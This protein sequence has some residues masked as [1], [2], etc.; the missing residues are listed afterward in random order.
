MFDLK[1][2]IPAPDACL[3]W[4]APTDTGDGGTTLT[5]LN[6]NVKLA[7][8]ANFSVGLEEIRLAGDVSALFSLFITLEVQG[9]LAHKKMPPP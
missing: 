7:E 8:D 6:Y 1:L 3:R 9:Y 2:R 5:I 4:V